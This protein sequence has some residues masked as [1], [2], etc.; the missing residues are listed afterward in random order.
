MSPKSVKDKEN[1]MKIKSIERVGKTPVYDISVKDAEQYVLKNGVVTHNT[2]PMYSSNNVFIIG[3]RQIKEG[4]DIIGWQFMLNVE[5]ST[6]ENYRLKEFSYGAFTRSF[7]LP[8]D[9]NQEDINAKVTNGILHLSISK[10]PEAE[11]KKI[12]IK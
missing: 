4:K 3:K 11:P 7:N 5:K 9:A 8:K 2:G 12:T 10:I 1:L 6:E